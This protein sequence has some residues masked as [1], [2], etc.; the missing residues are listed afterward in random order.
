MGPRQ[1]KGP[2]WTANRGKGKRRADYSSRSANTP[3]RDRRRGEKKLVRASVLTATQY[4][5]PSGECFGLLP[6]GR[7]LRRPPQ[8]F[9]APAEREAVAY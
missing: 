5:G 3:A 9:A 1:L 7:A 8:A 4:Q 2:R 6:E